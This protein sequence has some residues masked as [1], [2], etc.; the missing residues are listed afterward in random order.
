MRKLYIFC[1]I[2]IWFPKKKGKNFFERTNLLTEYIV[3]EE[4]Q[5]GIED[6]SSL[7]NQLKLVDHLSPILSIISQNN[8]LLVDSIYE[9]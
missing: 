5:N 9:K 8:T 6:N 2:I 7:S 1:N 3:H 4:E